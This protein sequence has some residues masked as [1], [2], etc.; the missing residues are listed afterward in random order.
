MIIRKGGFRSSK[1]QAIRATGL[2]L[3]SENVQ[4]MPATLTEPTG[5][6]ILAG[7]RTPATTPVRRAVSENQDLIRELA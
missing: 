6:G 7:L 2:G 1:K 4:K 3:W 5:R